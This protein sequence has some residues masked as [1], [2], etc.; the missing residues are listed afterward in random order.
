MGAPVSQIRRIA[1][2]PLAAQSYTRLRPD[3]IGTGRRVTHAYG[4]KSGNRWVCLG[5]SLFAVFSADAGRVSESG[6]GA[7]W[8]APEIVSSGIKTPTLA[9]SCNQESR[10]RARELVFETLAPE[11]ID[12]ELP[13]LMAEASHEVVD[14]QWNP[15]TSEL[16][17]DT[18]AP[19]AVFSDLAHLAGASAGPAA[20]CGSR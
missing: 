8:I 19:P 18:S 14:F 6:T 7:M 13:R 12:A 5:V 9:Q 11:D 2:R 16:S 17:F 4:V 1:P 10:A 15:A 3:P 20:S